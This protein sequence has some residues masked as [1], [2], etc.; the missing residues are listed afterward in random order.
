M[1]DGG[2]DEKSGTT[3]LVEAISSAFAGNDRVAVAVIFGSRAA[4][5]AKKGSD[6]DVAVLLAPPPAEG[7]AHSLIRDLHMQLADHV[8]VE[9]VDL[10]LLNDTPP[11]LA[12]RIL[13][14]G[15][16][17][18]CRDP[19]ALHRF[20]VRTFDMHSD[21]V[22]AEELFRRATRERATRKADHG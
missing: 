17:A 6:I 22:P 19:V 13:R 12:F 10:V 5:K 21:F 3:R 8:A 9:R 15:T 11:P 14:D 1:P 2:E 4:G 20:R 18:L 7:E 16:T